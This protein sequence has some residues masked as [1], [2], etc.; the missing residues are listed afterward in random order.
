MSIH[1]VE[2]NAGWKGAQMLMAMVGRGLLDR[3]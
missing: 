2:E 1:M 3:K